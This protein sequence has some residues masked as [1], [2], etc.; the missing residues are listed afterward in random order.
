LQLIDVPRV[1]ARTIF[2]EPRRAAAHVRRF[3]HVCRRLNRNLAVELTKLFGMI[4]A[5]AVIVALRKLRGVP[6]EQLDSFSPVE[7]LA[8]AVD[9]QR[10]WLA[11]HRIDFAAASQPDRRSRIRHEVDA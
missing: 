2:F 3:M 5:K 8:A 11:E 4:G 7:S 6:R 10:R 1:F 9:V